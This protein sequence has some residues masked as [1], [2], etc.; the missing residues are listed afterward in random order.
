MVDYTWV[1]NLLRETEAFATKNKI[2]RLSESIVAACTALI[3]DTEERAD[4][5]SD[6]R[7]WLEGIISQRPISQLSPDEPAH[8]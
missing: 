5:S 6:A 2:T 3:L 8:L 7:Q 4:I 1:V